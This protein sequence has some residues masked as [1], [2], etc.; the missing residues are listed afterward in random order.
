VRRPRASQPVALARLR[1]DFNVDD[2]AVFSVLE[3]EQNGFVLK[4]KEVE[5][6]DQLL[7]TNDFGVA[8]RESTSAVNEFFGSPDAIAFPSAIRRR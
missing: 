1:L 3:S 2:V 8:A 6:V 4:V 7:S 5:L